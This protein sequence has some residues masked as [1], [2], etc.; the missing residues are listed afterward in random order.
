MDQSLFILGHLHCS[1]DCPHFV[2]VLLQQW[3][4]TPIFQVSLNALYVPT[5]TFMKSAFISCN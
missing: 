5:Q 3:A 2:H 4:E 1:L